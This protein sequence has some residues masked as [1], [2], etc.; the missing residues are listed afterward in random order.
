MIDEL[1]DTFKKLVMGIV[2]LVL[3]FLVVIFI[4]KNKHL[5]LLDLN[6][7]GISPLVAD[8]S[9]YIPMWLY[10]F[11]MLAIGGGIGVAWMWWHDSP[12]RQDIINE[13]KNKEK[14]AKDIENIKKNVTKSIS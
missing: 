7:L 8:F 9:L 12:L 1:L 5:I 13:R 14:L 10:S 2:F 6:V 3:V 11:L 4:L